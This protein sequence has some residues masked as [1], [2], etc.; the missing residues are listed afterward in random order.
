MAE[1]TALNQYFSN[2]G[3]FYDPT[4]VDVGIQFCLASVD[5][6]GNPTNGIT[7]DFSQWAVFDMGNNPFNSI[8]MKNVNRWNPYRYL[9]IWIV[10]EVQNYPNAFATLPTAL[11]SNVDGVVITGPSLGMPHYLITHEVGHYLGLNHHH[12]TGNCNN[13]N[14]LLDG[15]NICDTPPQ[16]EGNYDCAVSTCSTE[17]DDTTG[18]NPFSSDMP[19][20][21]SLMTPRLNCPWVFTQGQ[22]DRMYAALTQIRTLLLSSN[23]CG[24]NNPGTTPTASFTLGEFGCNAIWLNYTGTP[25]EYIEW[26]I[27]NDGYF[28]YHTDSF[29]FQPNQSGYTSIIVRAF[30]SAGGDIDTQTVYLYSRPTTIYP[31]QTIQGAVPGGMCRGRT[32]TLTAVP[33][34]SSYHWSTGDTTQSISIVADTSFSITLT[35]IDSNGYVWQRC[36][37]TTVFYPVFPEPI[38]PPIYSLSGDSLCFSDTLIFTADLLPGQTRVWWIMNGFISPVPWDTMY[39]Y[40]PFTANNQIS[41]LIQDTNYCQAY[42]DTVTF[43]TDPTVPTP[44]EPFYWNYTLYGHGGSGWHHQF[45]LNGVAI[46]GADS[47]SYPITQP[48]CYSIFTY[49]QF[50][51]CGSMSDTVCIWLVGDGKLV[52]GNNFKL[53]PNPAIDQLSVEFDEALDGKKIQIRL[54]NLLGEEIQPMVIQQNQSS[55]QLDIAK[56]APGIYH[57]NLNGITRKFV[58]QSH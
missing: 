20:G 7:R 30:G 52:Q 3:P 38:K 43:Y 47:S 9:N 2:S 12:V 26:D 13:F 51:H 46:P 1:I 5:P 19:D 54:S 23:G 56:L 33:G 37:D 15:D 35:C 21:S 4:G 8:L 48:G 18:L 36:P 32:L 29:S 58:K 25:Y 14:C 11:G 34:M 28:E 31:L 16:I 55:L 6:Y 45:Y 40:H 17:M 27:N 24:N 50:P 42:L 53:Y 22:A 39:I 57:L 10:K 41:M 49:N 44:Y